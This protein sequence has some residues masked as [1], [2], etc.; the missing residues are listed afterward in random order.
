MP[1]SANSVCNVGASHKEVGHSEQD[2]N[3]LNH[4]SGAFFT[5]N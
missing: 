1:N 2:N 5:E 3:Q 4:W